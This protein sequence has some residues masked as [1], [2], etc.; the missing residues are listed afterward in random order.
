[1][2]EQTIKMRAD[3]DL[4]LLRADT[5][6]PPKRREEIVLRYWTRGELTPLA[7]ANLL[8]KQGSGIRFA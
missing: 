1:M 8:A 3:E 5:P 2:L 6:L 4:S 7:V